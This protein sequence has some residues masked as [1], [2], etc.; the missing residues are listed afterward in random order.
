M[1]KD[2][3]TRYSKRNGMINKKTKN[4]II[5][6]HIK[7]LDEVEQLRSRLFT[8]NNQ[9]NALQEQQVNLR[10]ELE[11]LKVNQQQQ[12]LQSLEEKVILLEKVIALTEEKDRAKVLNSYGHS[13]NGVITTSSST[14]TATSTGNSTTFTI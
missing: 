7:L 4:K 13:T 9:R 14:P 6:E 3:W 5:Q 2:K 11:E 8:S 12:Y 1:K 10:N